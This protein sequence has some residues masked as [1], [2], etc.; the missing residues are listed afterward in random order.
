MA[1][2]IIPA[3]ATTNAI[4]AGLIVLQCLKVLQQKWSDLRLVYVARH[5]EKALSSTNISK[6]NPNCA[7]CRTPYVH[8]AA[9]VNKLTISDFVEEVV[10][11]KVGYPGDV[12]V[13]DGS[14]ILFDPDAE[15][16]GAKTFAEMGIS[17]STLLTVDD[18]EGDLTSTVFVL[19]PFVKHLRLI[20]RRIE[21]PD[22]VCHE[23]RI[24]DESANWSIQSDIPELFEK[25]NVVPPQAD[26]QAESSASAGGTKRKADEAELDDEHSNKKQ[27]KK[28]KQEGNAIVL[29][30][31]DDEHTAAPTQNG[32]GHSNV[33]DLDDD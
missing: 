23:Y 13:R 20:M 9:D 18:E 4:V 28:Y 14:R 33:I 6:P 8:L 5:S 24:K 2:N 3:I 16:N 11:A 17:P 32:N 26:D 25:P 19:M 30:D 21:S 29:G 22:D 10:R 7:V 1:G 12:A 27:P 31:S 15:E